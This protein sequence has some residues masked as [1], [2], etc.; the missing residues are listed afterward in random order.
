MDAPLR[1]GRRHALHAMDAALVF[2]F[3]ENARTARAE[4]HLFHAAEFGRVAFELLDFETAPLGI[5]AIHP[6]KV[7]GEKRRLVA[8]G[9]RSDFHDCVAVLVRVGR[10]ERELDFLFR[11]VDPL[12]ERGDFGL[13]HLRHFGVGGLRQPG[14]VAE[15]RLRFLQNIPQRDEFLETR[16]FAHPFARL[17][18]VVEKIRLGDRR[19]EFAES[20][21]FF[22]DERCE[23]HSGRHDFFHGDTKIMGRTE[24]KVF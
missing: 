3:P 11:P 7:G 10:Q 14:V 24:G 22:F 15:F 13:C 2:H 4:N 18:R 23:V 12:F 8:A 17:L 19:F 5:P 9:A 20:L 21:D 1:L 6:V 16:V